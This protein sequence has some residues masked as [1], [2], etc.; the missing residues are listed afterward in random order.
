MDLA[1]G[2]SDD[3]RNAGRCL[4]V[5]KAPSS[6]GNP[7]ENPGVIESELFVNRR[8]LAYSSGSL[9]IASLF[10]AG[11]WLCCDTQPPGYAWV[12]DR[13]EQVLSGVAAG[14]EVKVKFLLKNTSRR[15]LR[16]LGGEAC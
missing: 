9:L 5:A 13:T 11:G 14:Q 3:R 10:L 4:R 7:G 12:L 2:G 16:L 1:A 8:L 15:S 6:G